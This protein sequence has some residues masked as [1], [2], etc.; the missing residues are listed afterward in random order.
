[1]LLPS[2]WTIEDL[3]LYVSE[4]CDFVYSNP[5]VRLWKGFSNLVTN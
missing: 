5:K 2:V 1:M 4:Y 3:N